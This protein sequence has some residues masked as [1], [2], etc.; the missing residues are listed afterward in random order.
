MSNLTNFKDKKELEVS[1]MD[2][3]VTKPIFKKC[4]QT[5]IAAAEVT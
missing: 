2:T 1:G 4:M 5:L 3:L